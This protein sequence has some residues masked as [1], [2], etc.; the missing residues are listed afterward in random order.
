MWNLEY[1]HLF[2]GIWKPREMIE[3]TCLFKIIYDIQY[4]QYAILICIIAVK[5]IYLNNIWKCGLYLQVVFT[6]RC[7]IV[8]GLCKQWNYN[9]CL[10]VMIHFQEMIEV[11]CLFKIIYMICIQYANLIFIIAAYPIFLDNIRKCGLYSQVVF[12]HRCYVVICLCKQ[13]NYDTG[14]AVMIHT[15]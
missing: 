7:N 1:K 13:W 3:V 4:I 8:I 14:L 10:T 11:A 5:P 15:Q 12:T 6:H 9:T 2:E